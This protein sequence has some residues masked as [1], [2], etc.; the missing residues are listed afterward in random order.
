MRVALLV[1]FLLTAG[2]EPTADFNGGLSS[3][4]E[5]GSRQLQDAS[6]R[7][8][9]PTDRTPKGALMLLLG[10]GIIALLVWAACGRR[11]SVCGYPLTLRRG[12]RCKIDGKTVMVCP[13]CGR[14]VTASEGEIRNLMR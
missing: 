9:S 3:Q 7:S 12:V 8:T 11:C 5:T 2:L 10:F 1:T 6:A 14:R 13:P 4:S